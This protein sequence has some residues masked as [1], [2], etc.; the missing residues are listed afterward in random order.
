MLYWCTMQRLMFESKCP[1]RA[2]LLGNLM[3]KI[4]M[5]RRQFI[6]SGTALAMASVAM[7]ALSLDGAEPFSDEIYAEAIASG[8][9]F[10]LDFTATW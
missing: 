10:L 1:T 7:P 8:E 4:V 2:N 5:N 6:Q 3:E 9:P